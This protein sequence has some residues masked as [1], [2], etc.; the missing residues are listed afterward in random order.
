MIVGVIFL[1][2]RLNL[3]AKASDAE[4]LVQIGEW[5]EVD[6]DGVIWDFTEAGKGTLTTNNHQ[7]DYSFIWEIEGNTLRVET[8]W[9]YTLD[10]AYT[11]TLDQKAQ[12]LTLTTD[13]GEVNFRPTGGV[14][15]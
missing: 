10:D 6:G 13:S 2:I 3:A 7:N 8:D 12:K 1:I 4:F 14:D 15:S 5:T 11:Y 9:L